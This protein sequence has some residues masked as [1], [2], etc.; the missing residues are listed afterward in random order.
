MR[1]IG[2]GEVEADE[3]VRLVAG[4]IESSNVRMADSLVDMIQISREFEVAVRMMSV[5]DDNAE[6]AATI[7]R[8]S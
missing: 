3:N 7:A 8:M 4:F 6:R 2:G 1:L 5:A